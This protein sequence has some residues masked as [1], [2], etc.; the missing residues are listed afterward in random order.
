MSISRH[1]Q[2]AIFILVTIPRI[3]IPTQ[4]PR[5]T[6]SYNLIRKQKKR[7]RGEKSSKTQLHSSNSYSILYK[8][9][10]HYHHFRLMRGDRRP[11]DQK[12]HVPTHLLSR[13]RGQEFPCS[14]FLRKAFQY[15]HALL[16]NER[17]WH[18]RREYQ[19]RFEMELDIQPDP[20]L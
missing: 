20:A 3:K 17:L 14:P 5:V 7:G 4:P 8:N 13:R 18:M 16:I 1:D 12:R 9:M 10:N 6:A 11:L 19:D 15:T 2:C